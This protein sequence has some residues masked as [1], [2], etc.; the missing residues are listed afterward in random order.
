MKYLWAE[1]QLF[2][3]EQGNKDI[4]PLSGLLKI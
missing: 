3:T 4:F 1:G 2:L